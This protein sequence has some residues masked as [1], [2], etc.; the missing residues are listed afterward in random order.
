M[1]VTSEEKDLMPSAR[2]FA[3]NLHGMCGTTG[4]TIHKDI[5]E[6][7]RQHDSAAC[8]PFD[9]SEPQANKDRFPRPTT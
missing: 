6:H 1:L 7:Q 5:I 4:V 2:K 9:Q 3:D 8:I